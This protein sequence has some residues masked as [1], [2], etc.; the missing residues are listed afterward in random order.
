M[1][2]KEVLHHE[3]TSLPCHFPMHILTLLLRTPEIRV[4]RYYT[5]LREIP[6]AHTGHVHN[7]K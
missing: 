5:W 6:L 3:A 2:A 1:Y 4:V 7:G